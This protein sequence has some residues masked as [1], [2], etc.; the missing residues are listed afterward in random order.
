M[1]LLSA[2]IAAEPSIPAGG[3]N[4]AELSDA[5]KSINIIIVTV[6]IAQLYW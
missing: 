5:A 4:W 3:E 2:A 6:L 1:I